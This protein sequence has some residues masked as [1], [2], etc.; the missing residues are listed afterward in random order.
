MSGSVAMPGIRC[1]GCDAWVT[2]PGI[3][4]SARPP[5][6]PL[7]IPQW[8]TR[9]FSAANA[10]VPWI[11]TTGSHGSNGSDTG[12]SS[13]RPVLQT[14]NH[15]GSETMPARPRRYGE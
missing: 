9:A 13:L 2:M 1:L 5:V 10:R 6:S 4:C 7:P 11:S 14:H 3:R 8:P 12:P 15:L